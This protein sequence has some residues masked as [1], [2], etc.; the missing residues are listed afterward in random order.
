[1]HWKWV[2][3]T[4]LL[5][6]GQMAT[7]AGAQVLPWVDNIVSRMVYYYSCSSY[8]SPAGSPTAPPVCAGDPG[9]LPAP[10]TWPIRPSAH[11]QDNILKTSFLSAAI[12]LLK[13]L[14]WE[15]GARSYKFTQIPELIH[16]LLVSGPPGRRPQG[17]P[18]P[19]VLSAGPG[20]STTPLL[21]PPSAPCRRSP[22]AWP[23]SSGRRSYWSSWDSGNS[24][25]GSRNED[26]PGPP[27]PGAGQ[28]VRGCEGARMRPRAR[29]GRTGAGPWSRAGPAATSGHGHQAQADGFAPCPRQAVNVCPY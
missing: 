13:A 17:P 2:S 20:A 25:S 1:M 3:S 12:M 8:V 14:K 15:D 5:C 24:P 18:G 10:P 6:Y 11:A 16:C 9:G 23:P 26:R 21:C 27:S 29:V 4:S 28:C 19:R 22:T 7:H